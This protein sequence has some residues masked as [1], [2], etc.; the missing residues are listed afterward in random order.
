MRVNFGSIEPKEIQVIL[1]KIRDDDNL[2]TSKTARD[3]VTRLLAPYEPIDLVQVLEDGSVIMPREK[4]ISEYDANLGLKYIEKYCGYLLHKFFTIDGSQGPPPYTGVAPEQ[5]E[6]LGKSRAVRSGLIDNFAIQPPTEAFGCPADD[7]VRS[8][9]SENFRILDIGSS[10][11]E[12]PFPKIDRLIVSEETAGLNAAPAGFLTAELENPSGS[13]H[14][15]THPDLKIN[16]VPVE[17]IDQPVDEINIKFDAPLLSVITGT[18]D[19]G[20]ENGVSLYRDHPFQGIENISLGH[21]VFAAMNQFGRRTWDTIRSPFGNPADPDNPFFQTIRI[22]LDEQGFITDPNSRQYYMFGGGRSGHNDVK[23]NIGVPSLEL[24]DDGRSAKVK[25]IDDIDPFTQ[26]AKFPGTYGMY[27][28]NR[29]FIEDTSFDELSAN[30]VYY[31]GDK[32]THLLYQKQRP[33]T[34]GILHG[35]V[36]LSSGV[37]LTASNIITWD[38]ASHTDIHMNMYY[39]HER[40][41][42]QGFVRQ[43]D[44]ERPYV[45]TGGPNYAV[46][47]RGK[48]DTIFSSLF[49]SEGGVGTYRY[50]HCY[51]PRGGGPTN[52]FKNQTNQHRKYIVEIAN[53]GDNPNAGH[54]SFNLEITAGVGKIIDV[55]N[56]TDLS[57][58]NGSTH[59]TTGFQSGRGDFVRRALHPA[60]VKQAGLGNCFQSHLTVGENFIQPL[61]HLHCIEDISMCYFGMPIHGPFVP[62]NATVGEA[63]PYTPWNYPNSLESYHSQGVAVPGFIIFRVYQEDNPATPEDESLFHWGP[64]NFYLYLHGNPDEPGR[65]DLTGKPIN[66]ITI[67]YYDNIFFTD[68]LG[69]RG[70]DGFIRVSDSQ[71]RLDCV[72]R[73]SRPLWTDSKIIVIAFARPETNNYKDSTRPVSGPLDI[74][75]YTPVMDPTQSGG[76]RIIDHDVTPFYKKYTDSQIELLK[77]FYGSIIG[78]FDASDSP[79]GDM[80]EQYMR[81]CLLPDY[82]GWDFDFCDRLFNSARVIPNVRMHQ[83]C[84]IDNFAYMNGIKV[85]RF[86]PEW[87]IEAGL[88]GTAGDIWYIARPAHRPDYI[89]RTGAD[90]PLT[91]LYGIYHKTNNRTF[92][93]HDGAVPESPFNP[94]M[95]DWPYDTRAYKKVL[96]DDKLYIPKLFEEIPQGEVRVSIVFATTSPIPLDPYDNPVISFFVTITNKAEQILKNWSAKFTVEGEIEDEDQDITNARVVSKVL[97]PSSPGVVE[98][99]VDGEG[100]TTQILPKESLTFYV[101]YRQNDTVFRD[102]TEDPFD[103]SINVNAEDVEGTYDGEA[104]ILPKLFSEDQTHPFGT[105]PT[106]NQTYKGQGGSS[107]Q[108]FLPDDRIN[109]SYPFNYPYYDACTGYYKAPAGYAQLLV[110]VEGDMEVIV[111]PP[112]L[113]EQERLQR[114]CRPAVQLRR[115]EAATIAPSANLFLNNVHINKIRP[116]GLSPKDSK[117]P[118]GT[119][120]LEHGPSD[121]CYRYESTQENGGQLSNTRLDDGLPRVLGKNGLLISTKMK[122]IVPDGVFQGGVNPCYGGILQGERNFVRTDSVNTLGWRVDLETGEYLPTARDIPSDYDKYSPGPFCTP[123]GMGM[124][125]QDLP[126]GWTLRQTDI[127]SDDDPYYCCENCRCTM[128][129]NS[130]GQTSFTKLG[131]VYDNFGIDL[132]NQGF[133]DPYDTALTAIVNVSATKPDMGCNLNT[134]TGPKWYESNNA[135]FPLDGGPGSIDPNSIAGFFLYEPLFKIGPLIGKHSCCAAPKSDLCPT[136]TIE[137]GAAGGCCEG[138]TDEGGNG[139]LVVIEGGCKKSTGYGGDFELTATCSVQCH[140]AHVGMTA[141]RDLDEFPFPETLIDEVYP[142]NDANINQADVFVLNPPSPYGDGDNPFGTPA[143]EW[144][145]DYYALERQWL[146]SCGCTSS[147]TSPPIEL[148]CPKNGE[149]TPITLAFSGDGGSVVVTWDWEGLFFQPDSM[150]RNFKNCLARGYCDENG[151]STQAGC[152]WNTVLCPVGSQAFQDCD[153]DVGSGR[154]CSRDTF[155]GKFPPNVGGSNSLADG[156]GGGFPIRKACRGTCWNPTPQ[157]YIDDPSNYVD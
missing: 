116:T 121:T 104:I 25:F 73:S 20:S 96:R 112:D 84:S 22:P 17:F 60:Q 32:G 124:P 128:F 46:G 29:F 23:F 24:A 138:S 55:T 44:A 153:R 139:I 85:D 36:S 48:R 8:I 97:S 62:D 108:N 3:L 2:N 67:P 126:V 111:D 90:N 18:R 93:R 141:G 81:E 123:Q 69:I 95:R 38:I 122:D 101:T 131:I 9:T 58:T 47:G 42:D 35:G 79:Y 140:N 63:I 78:F 74:P 98:Y 11:T 14:T 144:W 87:I 120:T 26:S 127:C 75:R 133:A 137:I 156:V 70:G 151:I 94:M 117:V 107:F 76:V 7:N 150:V 118:Q 134:I 115:G 33:D 143:E 13:Y 113:T 6:S 106:A 45:S 148:P 59:M 132:M 4:P 53:F 142:S 43:E 152:D 125:Y 149:T 92:Y 105:D 31:P 102:V 103:S 54:A 155:D 154:V 12:L 99:T 71:V 21:V 88:G 130:V 114:R 135:M 110:T 19:D 1:K 57:V 147:F 50:H 82:G 66:T 91:N 129:S 136:F 49:S 89:T 145:P 39:V 28:S 86:F 27:L 61:N 15:Y 16:N 72:L 41:A 100:S 30:T 109:N 77:N 5:V 80:T 51:N 40:V 65:G 34:D 146:N 68:I 56:L 83:Q 64:N 37:T 10:L 52:D 157:G 119:I